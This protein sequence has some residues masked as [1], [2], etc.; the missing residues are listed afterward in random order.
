MRKTETTGV[1]SRPFAAVTGFV[2]VGG[3]STRMGRPKHQL[4][5]GGETM[6]ARQVRLLKRSAG[7]VE[8]LGTP[9]GPDVLGGSGIKFRPD[10]LP[11]RGPLG[12]IYTG[13]IHS[14]TE[15][16]L[17]LGCDLP[18]MNSDFLRYLVRRALQSCADATAP[19]SPDGRL[20]PLCAVYR[21]RAR[22]A[23][24][25]S[26]E[27]GENAVRSFFAHVRCLIIPWREIAS[28][29]FTPEILSNMNTPGDYERAAQIIGLRKRSK[30]MK[31]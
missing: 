9:S 29:G 19:K 2:L 12:G 20:H 14:R 17:F 24:K 30:R 5:L 21:R 6:L 27:S 23:V 11:G 10:D 7:R 16:N 13:L 15:F 28:E 3:A 8:A 25:E 18:F 31:G 4:V 26:L 1:R 22:Q